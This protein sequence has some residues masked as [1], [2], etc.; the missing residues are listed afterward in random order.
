METSAAWACGVFEGEGSITTRHG[1]PVMQMKMCD[2]ETVARFAEAVG[3]PGRVLGPYKN[4]AG[5]KD[6]YA[7]QDFYVWTVGSVESQRVLRMLWPWLG[8]VRRTRAAE[9]GFATP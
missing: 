7:R 2:R 8:S 1:K 3:T 6:G 5:E 4:R 9:V